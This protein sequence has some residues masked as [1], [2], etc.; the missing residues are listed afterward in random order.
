MENSSRTLY[1]VG[2]PLASSRQ[3]AIPG[4]SDLPGLTIS[5]QNMMDKRFILPRHILCS[6][7]IG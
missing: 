1:E 2:D 6:L 3:Q 4:S 7:G 5:T